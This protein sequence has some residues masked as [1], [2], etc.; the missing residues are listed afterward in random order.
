MLDLLK[1]GFGWITLTYNDGSKKIL[2]TTLNNELLNKEGVALV[3]D[4]LYD[5]IKKEY[6]KLPENATLEVTKEKPEL[7][8]VNE[9]A[10]RFI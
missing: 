8:E 3:E 1:T 4:S 9:F 2:K 10:N 7:N 5:F 6:V